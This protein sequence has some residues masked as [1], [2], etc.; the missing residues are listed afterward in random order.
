MADYAHMFDATYRGENCQFERQGMGT[1]GERLSRWDRI[2]LDEAQNRRL[3]VNQV[4]RVRTA[5][6]KRADE[7][8][9]I[10]LLRSLLE[11]RGLLRRYREVLESKIEWQAGLG[12]RRPATGA[13][14]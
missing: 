7:T 5:R 14:L 13:G 12:S 11:T 6:S 2:A 8:Q 3:I 4:R 10:A 9:S 1:L